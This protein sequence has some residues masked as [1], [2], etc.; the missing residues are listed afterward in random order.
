M[1]GAAAIVAAL[2]LAGIGLTYLFDRHVMRSLASDLEVQLRQLV[3][4]VELNSTGQPQLLR[5]PADPRFSEPLSGLYWQ[6]DAGS[7]AV[8]SSRSL[9]DAALALP[10]DDQA[11]GEVHYHRLAGPAHTELLG[12]ERTVFLS[13]NGAPTPVRIA[14]AAD[15]AHITQAR[16]TFMRELVPSLAV[17]A[18]CWRPRH[19]CRSGWVAASGATARRYRGHPRRPQRLAR[20]SCAERS[21]AAGA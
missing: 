19:G 10:A 2:I 21:G 15:L 9:W 11:A 4:T 3:A 6:L 7:G 16:H 20:R 1:G 14:V 8:T 12:V 18:A 5:E 13:A 17:L